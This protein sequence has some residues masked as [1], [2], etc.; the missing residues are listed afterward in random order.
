LRL[1]ELLNRA[2]IDPIMD[3]EVTGITADSRHVQPGNL[4]AAMPGSVVDGWSYVEG[5]IT[6]GAIAVLASNDHQEAKLGIYGH[7]VDDPRLELAQIA[8][9]FEGARPDH[10]AAVTGTNGKTSVAHF[11]RQIWSLLGVN[12]ASIGTLGL[13]TDD[14]IEDL[15]YTTP[16]PVLLHKV[17][18]RLKDSGHARSYGLSRRCGKLPQSQAGACRAGA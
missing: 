12:A 6:S 11:T 8:D 5:A 18:H 17:L 4:F 14:A 2:D 3:A 7:Y 1:S 16:D 15:H 9:R 13:V 10:V